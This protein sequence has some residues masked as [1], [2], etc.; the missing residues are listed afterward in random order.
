MEGGAE[1]NVLDHGRLNAGP[2][3]RML[4]HMASQIDTVRIIQG[5]AIGLAKTRTRRGND[6]CFRHVYTPLSNRRQPY[7]LP[8]PL[9]SL[10]R[11]SSNAAG[12]HC[13]PPI[14]S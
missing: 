8:K 4:D 10:T 12:F 2:L 13:S 1:D 7:R 11:R 9:P 5:T 14:R 6:N 3:N